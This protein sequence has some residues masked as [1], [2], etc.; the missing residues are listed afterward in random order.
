MT[1]KIQKRIVR[2]EESSKLILPLVR[3]PSFESKP[4]EENY[5][6]PRHQTGFCIDMP[7]A[8]FRTL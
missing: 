6:E 2:L 8:D 7:L 3:F 5:S 4:D 1:S